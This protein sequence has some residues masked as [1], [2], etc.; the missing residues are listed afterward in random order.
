MVDAVYF[1]GRSAQRHAV[2]LELDGADLLVSGDG[3]DRRDALGSLRISARL[4]STPRALDFADGAR[5]EV[6]E[7]EAFDTLL[8][9]AARRGGWLH[10]AES[11]W[12]MIALSVVVV[13]ACG[14]ALFVWGIPAGAQLVARAMPDT[15]SRALSDQ[16]MKLFDRHLLKPTRLDANRTAEL[17]GRL[18]DLR[19]PDGAQAAYRIEFRS[20]PTLGPNAFALPDGTIVLLDEL[21]TLADNDE[22]IAAVVGH[23]LGHV[24][25]RHGLRLIAQNSAVGVLAAWWLGDV[26]A[27]LAA[28]PTLLIQARYS[29]EFE[30]EA[31]RYAAELMRRNGIAPSRLAELLRKLAALHP[32][33]DDDGAAGLLASHPALLE[34]AR[35]LD[36]ERADEAA[37]A[38]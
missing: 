27:L 9:E 5:C 11:S 32:E 20:A 28:A 14:V 3:V 38:H 33:A 2:R 34:R 4:G 1:D 17:T 30:S 36:G 21:V 12:R 8:R 25:Y 19:A 6:R 15:L 22:Q 7:H 37:A 18:E 23:E 16:T 13:A 35:A 10:R 31:D 26:S 24:Y 29:R